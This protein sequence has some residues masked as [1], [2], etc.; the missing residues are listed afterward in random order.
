MTDRTAT[1]RI[2]GRTFVYT[3]HPK[4]GQPRQ[5]DT[6]DCKLY[7]HHLGR[8]IGLVARLS[9]G[10]KAGYSPVSEPP[11]RFASREAQR[12]A[13]RELFGLAQVIN[14]GHVRKG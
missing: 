2:C 8:L 11:L 4:G 9:A 14:P 1:C 10:S 13:Y 12:E 7:S 5:F 6:E 3:P